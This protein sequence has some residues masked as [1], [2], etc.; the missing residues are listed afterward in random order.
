MEVL[1]GQDSLTLSHLG[2]PKT[3]GLQNRMQG[4]WWHTSL[5]AR[6]H[7]AYIFSVYVCD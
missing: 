1:S 7:A 5:V 6:L 2:N 4:L 3:G